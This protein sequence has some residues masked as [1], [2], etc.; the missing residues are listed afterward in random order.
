[1]RRHGAPEGAP[2]REN[3]R[4]TGLDQGRLA[5]FVT[6]P[7]GFGGPLRAFEI[8]KALIEA[9]A[10]G[11]HFEDQL[12]SEKK[13]GHLGGK[14]LVPTSQFIRTLVAARLASDVLGVPT[15]VFARTDS[16][17]ATLLTSDVDEA[18]AAFCTGERTSEVFFRVRHGI[19]APRARSLG[20]V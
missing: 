15:V 17:A 11:V 9:D 2:S 8:K 18:D 14:V 10:A 3:C 6:F 5:K 20:P 12:S 7:P 16:H 1:M 13:C 4:D 19:D